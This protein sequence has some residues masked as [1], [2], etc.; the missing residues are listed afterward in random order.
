MKH[1]HDFEAMQSLLFNKT[2]S[3]VMKTGLLQTVVTVF[4]VGRVSIERF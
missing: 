1:V 4:N 3:C 2:L